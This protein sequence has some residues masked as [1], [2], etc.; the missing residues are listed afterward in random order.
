MV[1]RQIVVIGVVAMFLL[2]GLLAYW[3]YSEQVRLAGDKEIAIMRAK[4]AALEA[5]KD[6]YVLTIPLTAEDDLGQAPSSEGPPPI[7]GPDRPN[8]AREAEY[9]LGCMASNGYRQNPE[10][11]SSFD[12]DHAQARC[13]DPDPPS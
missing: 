12:Y 10:L 2:A 7:R 6:A 13:F 1:Q 3:V 11:C 5:C 4:E 8:P 9:I